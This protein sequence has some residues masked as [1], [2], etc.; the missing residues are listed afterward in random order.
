MYKQSGLD[1]LQ[2]NHAAPRKLEPEQEDLLFLFIQNHRPSD[3]GLS[4]NSEW[5]LHLVTVWIEREFKKSYLKR[6]V[7]HLLKQLGLRTLKRG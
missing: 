6:G 1:W 2:S 3:L 4:S 5:T 7:A